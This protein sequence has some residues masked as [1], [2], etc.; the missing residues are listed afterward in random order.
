MHV[1]PVELEL[2]RLLTVRGAVRGSAAGMWGSI[3]SC[4]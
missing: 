4:E 3:G 1:V 2:M